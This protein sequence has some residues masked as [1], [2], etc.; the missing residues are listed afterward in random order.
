[1]VVRKFAPSALILASAIIVL[2]ITAARAE[3][4]CA[5][6]S[7]ITAQL[8]RGKYRES[9]IA[10]AI[11]DSGVVLIVF[12]ADDGATWTLIGVRAE[13]PDLGCFLGSGTSWDAKSPASPGKRS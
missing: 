8:A 5:P 12:A 2:S 4:A 9:P 13:R 11:A 1:M 3:V 10:H 6:L 7:E